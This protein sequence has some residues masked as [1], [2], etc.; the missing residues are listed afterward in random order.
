MRSGDANQQDISFAV[1]IGPNRRARLKVRIRDT[2]FPLHLP[3]EQ[4][5][6]L[7]LALLAASAACNVAETP[8]E[9]TVIQNCHFPV[10]KWGTGHSNSNGMPVLAVQVAGGAQLVLQFDSQA[11]QECGSSLMTAG[12][13]ERAA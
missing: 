12:T 7:G 5:A 10:M 8:A 4:A 13:K 9:G 2:E 11:A 3:A 1:E 6:E